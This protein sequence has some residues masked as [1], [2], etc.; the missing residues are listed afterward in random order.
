MN[1]VK[2]VARKRDSAATKAAILR[3]ARVRFANFSYEQVRLKDIAADAKCDVALIGRYFTSKENLYTLVLW[4]LLDPDNLIAGDRA[5]FGAR[6]ARSILS[7]SP[8]NID[9]SPT[10]VVVHGATSGTTQPLLQKMMQ[11]RFLGPIADWLGGK[12]RLV[13]A[14]LVAILCGGAVIHQ[15]AVPQFAQTS[16]LKKAYERALADALQACV[17]PSEDT[18]HG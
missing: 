7:E 12:D 5:T 3:A 1:R 11:E 8:A 9:L 6:I 15:K 13:K 10:L 2:P 16:K 18:G 4:E 17:G 14:Q